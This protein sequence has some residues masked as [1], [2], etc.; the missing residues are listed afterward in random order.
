MSRRFRPSRRAP[1]LL[2]GLL[3]L[4]VLVRW[5]QDRSRPPAPEV[6]AEGRCRVARVID[7]DTLLLA[8][9]ARL[10]LI[11]IDT[12]ELAFEDRPAEP[13]AAEAT[14][15]T[16][17]FLARGEVILRFDRERLDRY[18]RFLAYV[19]VEDKLLN[20]ELVRAGLARA[21]L[22]FHYSESMKRRFRKA[23]DEA[24]RERKGVWQAP[25]FKG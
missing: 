20:E 15:F 24:R 6:L 9:G 23:E 13:L 11:G 25:S 19:W 22:G 3:C 1:S 4:L 8:D 14:A 16:R 5:W 21:R 10:R 7:G 17:R 12:P 18:G 2:I